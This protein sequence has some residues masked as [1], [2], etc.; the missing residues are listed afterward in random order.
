MFR[1]TLLAT[2]AVAP[3]LVSTAPATAPVAAAPV[4]AVAC[5]NLYVHEPVVVFES[6]GQTP[7]GAA[8]FTLTVYNDGKVRATKL[9]TLTQVVTTQSTT[10][11]SDEWIDLVSDLSNAGAGVLCDVPS[12]KAIPTFRFSTLTLLREGTD[13][14]GHTFSWQNAGLLEASTVSQRVWDFVAVQFPGI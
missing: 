7:V 6:Q 4:A 9:D 1:P 12:L 10:V 13:T 3:F 5:P 2:L 14:K 11:T 8:E